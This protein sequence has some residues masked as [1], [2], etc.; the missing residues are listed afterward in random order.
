MKKIAKVGFVIK[1]HAPGVGGVLK[2]L[3]AWF[4]ARGIGCLLEKAAARK[5]GQASAGLPKEKLP[6][7]CDLIVVLGGDGTLL[8]IAYLAADAGI[9]V[10]GINMGRLG[11]LTEVPVEEMYISLE[12][13]LK[14][15][16]HCVS[17]RRM[18]EARHGRTS[19][20]CLNDVVVNKGALAR[21]IEV[22][23]WIDAKEVATLKADGL[24][25][26]TATGSTAYSLS[27]GGPIIQPQIGAAVITPIC[28]H[29][30]TFRPIVIS[31]RS[32][33]R[34]KLLTK[35][36]KVFYTLDGQRG[37]IIERNDS[38]TVKPSSKELLLV[39]SPRRNFFDLVKEKLNW[40]S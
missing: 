11:F 22:T 28:P 24:I 31:S 34:V 4:D 15:S 20:F 2:E 32:T 25:I 1:P 39:T 3:C 18:L 7:R 21:M 23:I 19:A 29:T 36:E 17:R 33:V 26:S 27:A 8:S 6:E 5:L 37:G 16:R 38:I 12:A 40:A 14:G 10:M 30:L 9:P 13:F 35:G